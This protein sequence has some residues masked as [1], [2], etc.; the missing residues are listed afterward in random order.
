MRRLVIACAGMLSLFGGQA[1]AAETDKCALKQLANLPLETLA[2]GRV[3]IPL[4]VDGKPFFFMVD[5]GGVS[6]TMTWEQAQQLGHEVKR[7]SMQLIGVGGSAMN[8][9]ITVDSMVLGWMKGKNIPIYLET[10]GMKDVDGTMSPDILKGYDVDFDFARS[11]MNIFS[12]DHCP[13]TVV[14]WT[15]TGFVVIPMA[16]DDMGH[17]RIPIK[18][19]GKEIMATLDTGAVNSLMSMRTAALLGI[20]QRT[21]GMKMVHDAGRNSFYSYPFKTLDLDGVTVS[22][23][24]ITIASDSFT[25]DM[26]NDLILGMGIL[27]QLHLYIAYGEQKLYITP[28]LAN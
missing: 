7:S 12:K 13:G 3:A 22:N 1:M 20:D 15:K 8:S 5:T 24:Y 14:H 28:A 25:K 17:V 4:M 23:P 6:L 18:V 21:P 10:R 2:D 26:G 16:V 19:D 9:Y 11:I 27:R